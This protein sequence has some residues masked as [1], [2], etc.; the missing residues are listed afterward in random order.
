MKSYTLTLLSGNDDDVL[1]TS[2]VSVIRHYLHKRI[3]K[4]CLTH[5]IDTNIMMSGGDEE[6]VY[7][8]LGTPCGAE[9]M[10]EEDEIE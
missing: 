9:W 6:I 7:E 5:N 2:D 10:L 3:C 4:D 1:I 8:L